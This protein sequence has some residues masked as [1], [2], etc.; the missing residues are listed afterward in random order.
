MFWGPWLALSRSMRAF[1]P[2]VFLAI[3]HRLNRNMAPLMTALMPVGLLSFVPLLVIAYGER[4]EMFYVGLA[5]FGLFIVALI[6]T[7]VVEV[8]I[9]KQMATWT[10]PTLPANWMHLRDR[11][12]AFH[13]ARIFPSIG[14]LI[15]L[16]AGAI[17]L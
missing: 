9:V 13:L 11:W 7:M 17:Y 8:P 3:V 5:S 15:L 4:R 1:E 2:E 14:G 10:V 16:V 6:V 12:G